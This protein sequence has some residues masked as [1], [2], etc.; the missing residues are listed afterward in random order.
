VS[1]YANRS[2]QT[3]QYRAGRI[4]RRCGRY[5][6]GLVGRVLIGQARLADGGRGQPV[7]RRKLV[8]APAGLAGVVATGEVVLEV[9]A[10]LWRPGTIVPVMP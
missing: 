2:E 6:L 5:A 1:R 3:S 10:K 9:N 8:V 4:H 7:R